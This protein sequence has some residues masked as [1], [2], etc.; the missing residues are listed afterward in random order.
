[1]VGLFRNL[2][3]SYVIFRNIW[4]VTKQRKMEIEHS[5]VKAGS[6]VLQDLFKDMDEWVENLETL[7]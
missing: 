7:Y 1:M 4:L 3:E 6:P 5:S 2:L